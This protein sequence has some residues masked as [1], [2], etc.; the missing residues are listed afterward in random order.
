MGL[1][2]KFTW[3]SDMHDHLLLWLCNGI[4][5]AEAC[6]ACLFISDGLTRLSCFVLAC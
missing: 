6:N 3:C 2:Q 5:F 4:C 1:L